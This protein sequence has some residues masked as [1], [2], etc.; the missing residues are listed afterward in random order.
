MA[1]LS[2]AQVK[3]VYFKTIGGFPHSQI[4]TELN[5]YH[6]EEQICVGCT[7]LNGEEIKLIF[8]DM[9]WYSERDKKRILKEWINFLTTNTKALRALHFNSH[10]PQALFNAACCQENLE[11]LRFK[12][13]KYSDLSA[14]TKLDKL[15]YLYIGP[16]ASVHDI[17]ILGKLTSLVVL[18]VVALKKIEDYSPLNTLSNLEQLV[19]S[20]RLFGTTPTPIKD[21]EF[22]R[23]MQNLRSILVCHVRIR[24]KYS[25]EELSNLK[26]AVPNLHDICNC[27]FD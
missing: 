24:K 4:I 10:V 11:E 20:G 7:Q 17:T 3:D 19:I 18:H 25:S 2:E 21:L 9:K 23:A 14:L 6:G 26:L 5:E 16:G 12:W 13:G 1:I 8:H 15:K 22:L 27:V